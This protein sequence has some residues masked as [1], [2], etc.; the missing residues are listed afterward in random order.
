MVAA[1]TTK[2]RIL[3]DNASYNYFLESGATDN[4]YRINGI[5]YNLGTR[6]FQTQELVT[7][8]RIT[9]SSEFFQDG[10]SINSAT[11]IADDFKFKVIASNLTQLHSDGL[12]QEIII[13]DTDQSSNR[14]SIEQNINNHYNIY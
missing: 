10:T 3:G 6:I 4:R 11:V 2:G 1:N 8:S 7:W 12:I 5:I 9:T 14:V 13:Y